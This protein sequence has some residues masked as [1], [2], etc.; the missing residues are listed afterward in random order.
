MIP[1]VLSIT[2]APPFRA[3]PLEDS[4]PL[5][6]SFK[7][8][9]E[10]LKSEF[11]E[12]LS[13]SKNFSG[14]IEKMANYNHKELTKNNHLKDIKIQ[15]NNAK[16]ITMSDFKFKEI[17]SEIN[18][19]EIKPNN[20]ETKVPEFGELKSLSLGIGKSIGKIEEYQKNFID[21]FVDFQ[22]IYKKKNLK[23]T[24]ENYQNNLLFYNSMS[25]IMLCLLAGGLV[26]VIFILYISF[27][28]SANEGFKEPQN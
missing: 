4:E 21:S 19:K 6:D 17:A 18:I 16:N 13:Y 15:G 23:Q 14:E 22:D 5:Y 26:G 2:S 11:D 7:H 10:K 25:L 27:N 24:K 1:Y 3:K 9:Y 28:A 8:N 12:L 20:D